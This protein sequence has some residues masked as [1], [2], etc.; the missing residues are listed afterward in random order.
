MIS[1]G[2]DCSAVALVKKC[3]ICSEIWYKRNVTHKQ[4]QF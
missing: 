1:A 4:M 2:V 3:T